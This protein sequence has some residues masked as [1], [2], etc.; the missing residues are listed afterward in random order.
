MTS[1]GILSRATLFAT[2]AEKSNIP[3]ILI[4]RYSSFLPLSVILST[5]SLVM[6][7]LANFLEA[8]TTRQDFNLIL[9]PSPKRLSSSIY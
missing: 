4:P 5:C 3:P 7:K 1:V 8:R 2:L 6:L 9:I